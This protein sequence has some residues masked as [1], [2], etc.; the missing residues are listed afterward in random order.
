MPL[1]QHKLHIQHKIII[2]FV[3]SPTEIGVSEPLPS[4]VGLESKYKPQTL[5]EKRITKVGIT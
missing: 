4:H 3:V 2:F 1:K 5:P